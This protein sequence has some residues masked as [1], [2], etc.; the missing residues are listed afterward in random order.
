MPKLVKESEINKHENTNIITE[1]I[2][3]IFLYNIFSLLFNE[4]F[5]VSIGDN[6]QITTKDISPRNNNMHSI[7]S[8]LYIS[9][10]NISPN[11]NIVVIIEKT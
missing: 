5:P 3:E 1:D 8:E 10:I 9:I 7:N 4:L 2:M 11:V 6:K